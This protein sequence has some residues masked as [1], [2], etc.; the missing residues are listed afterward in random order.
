[1]MESA[2]ADAPTTAL[3]IKASCDNA[4]CRYAPPSQ[5]PGGVLIEMTPGPD[6]LPWYL[7]VGCWIEGLPMKKDQDARVLEV[8]ETEA[9]QAAKK[10]KP[11]KKTS[12]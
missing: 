2:D 11:K 1:M 3:T 8:A 7:C 4:R 6:G 9:E 12:D 10:S 5:G